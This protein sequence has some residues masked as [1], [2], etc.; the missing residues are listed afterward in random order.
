MGEFELFVD[1]LALGAFTWAWSSQDKDDSC[2]FYSF[3]QQI[4]FIYKSK[5]ITLYLTWKQEYDVSVDYKNVK[6]HFLAFPF[7]SIAY[8]PSFNAAVLQ[9]LNLPGLGKTIG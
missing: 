8:L 4:L 5:S 7:S 9:V 3:H 6:N 2:T 1:L